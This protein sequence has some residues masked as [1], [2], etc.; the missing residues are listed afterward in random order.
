MKID[1]Q[2]SIAKVKGELEKHGE[3]YDGFKASIKSVLDEAPNYVP[4]DELAD[5]ILKR[6]VGEE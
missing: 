6:I 1:M 4:N 5:H 3:L 2:I